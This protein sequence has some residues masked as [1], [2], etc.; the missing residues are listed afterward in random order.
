MNYFSE[1]VS[2]DLYLKIE[3]KVC[4]DTILKWNI[5]GRGL[6]GMLR[7]MGVSGVL[8]SMCIGNVRDIMPRIQ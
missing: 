5:G 3:S 8:T 4:G 1:S 7:Y 6:L 2:I